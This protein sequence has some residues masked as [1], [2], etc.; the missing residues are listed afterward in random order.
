MNYK[1][2]SELQRCA[3]QNLNNATRLEHYQKRQQRYLVE[4]V[5]DTDALI[6]WAKNTIK[7]QG[8]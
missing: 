1:P 4:F 2:S 5:N 6:A 8:E 7:R 3:E